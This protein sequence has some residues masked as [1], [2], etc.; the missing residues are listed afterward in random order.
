MTTTTTRSVSDDLRSVPLPD[1]CTDTTKLQIAL[2]DVQA[3]A[4][5]TLHEL[6]ALADMAQLAM[7]SP[8]FYRHPERLACVLRTLNARAEDMADLIYNQAHSVGC[9]EH[10]GDDLLRRW[11]AVQAFE[12]SKRGA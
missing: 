6:G 7:Q 10:P 4:C 11:D 1:R 5:A 2:I 9:V 3:L 8:D 12:Q